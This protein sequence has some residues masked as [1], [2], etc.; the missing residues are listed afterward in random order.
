M[1]KKYEIRSTKPETNPKSK[2]SNIKNQILIARQNDEVGQAV[3]PG[4]ECAEDF[5]LANLFLDLIRKLF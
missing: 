4:L 2:F 3:I 5:T 1:N